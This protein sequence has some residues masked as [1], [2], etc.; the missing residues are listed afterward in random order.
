MSFHIAGAGA[1]DEPVCRYAGSA[2]SY[3][4]PCASLDEPYIAFLG[5][6]ETYGRFVEA[7]FP[8]LTDR[9][10]GRSCVNLGCVNAGLDTML[11]DA[12]LMRIAAGAE[13]VVLQLPGAQN[14]SNRYYRVHPRRNDRFL[15]PTGRLAA[16]YP[17]VDFTEFHFTKHLLGTLL[18]LGPDR[19]AA[20]REEL[21]DIWLDR[22]DRL[23]RALGGRVL[24]LWLQY[25]DDRPHG[26]EALGPDPL[27][28]TR[29]MID[30]VRGESRGLIEVAVAPAC[31]RAGEMEKM[32]YG[33]LQAPAAEHMLGPGMH[34]RIASRLADRL[35]HLL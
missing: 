22:M 31:Q 2:L 21:R 23:L 34:M 19:F 14:L 18:R 30:R 26:D 15:A 1:L 24:L 11:N 6:N 17:D 33:P 3:R 12:G 7:P 4:G 35:T 13:L 10:L 9:L 20:I 25:A 8:L 27:L 28:L 5:G 29:S 32:A 16:L